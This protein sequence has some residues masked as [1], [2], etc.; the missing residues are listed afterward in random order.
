MSREQ[1]K[2]GINCFKCR[3]FYVTWDE[4]FPYGCRGMGFKSKTKPS[5]EV[6]SISGVECLKFEASGKERKR[7]N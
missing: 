2:S 3:Y 4:R 7:S 5:D 1:K 6:L